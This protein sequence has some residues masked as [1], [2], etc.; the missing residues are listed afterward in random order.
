MRQTM[1]AEIVMRAVATIVVKRTSRRAT[2]IVVGSQ[3]H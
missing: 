1:G 3:M 2:E